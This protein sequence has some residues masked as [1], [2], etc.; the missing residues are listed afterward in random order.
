MSLEKELGKKRRIMMKKKQDGN[1]G[2]P[3]DK[4][5]PPWGLRLENTGNKAG[6]QHKGRVENIL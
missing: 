4:I 3:F 1:P 2:R 6:S 5:F